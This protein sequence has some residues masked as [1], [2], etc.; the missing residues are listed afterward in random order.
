MQWVAR[1]DSKIFLEPQ[2][3]VVSRRSLAYCQV[4]MRIGHLAV[5]FSGRYAKTGFAILVMLILAG[6]DTKRADWTRDM[7]PICEIH[8]IQMTQTNVPINYGLYALNAYGE[9][10]YAASSNSF[11][12]AE[13]KVEGGCMVDI[14]QTRRSMFVSSVSN[15]GGNGSCSIPLREEQMCYVHNCQSSE[16]Y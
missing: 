3:P 9:A 5:G 12:H 16:R 7:C 13:E 11:P 8:H 14:Q 4:E 2:L 6:C 15:R 1:L 10:F